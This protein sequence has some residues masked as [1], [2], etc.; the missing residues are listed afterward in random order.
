M[1]V[2]R[3][4]LT[5]LAAVIEKTIAT[6]F[7]NDALVV[8]VT[9]IDVTT[10]FADIDKL[11]GTTPNSAFISANQDVYRRYLQYYYRSAPLSE[12]TRSVILGDD[13]VSTAANYFSNW[14]GEQRVDAIKISYRI[15]LFSQLDSLGLDDLITE[16]N[17]LVFEDQ[18]VGMVTALFQRSNKDYLTLLAGELYKRSTI[19]RKFMV[20]PGNRLVSLYEGMIASASLTFMH[21]RLILEKNKDKP[22]LYQRIIEFMA[23]TS[24]VHM[25]VWDRHLSKASKDTLRRYLDAQY[26]LFRGT[27]EDAS[28]SNQRGPLGF[29]LTTANWYT[30][31]EITGQLKNIIK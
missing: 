8:P 31:S 4:D 2:E 26:I 30:L 3:F 23:R 11:Y 21:A 28:P 29:R 5:N 22:A 20:V 6:T 1:K 12:V 18:D 7:G 10:D 25:N 24:R 19:I 27:V 13:T 9:L 14:F 16:P 17:N 15:P